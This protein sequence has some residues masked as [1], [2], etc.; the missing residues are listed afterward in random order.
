MRPSKQL[1]KPRPHFGHPHH[2]LLDP[3]EKPVQKFNQ[4][5]IRLRCDNHLRIGQKLSSASA[6]TPGSGWMIHD[7][8]HANTFTSPKAPKR[9]SKRSTATK[10]A[11]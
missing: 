1:G 9:P 11:K 10:Q 4:A 3:V 2:Q 8:N 7:D 6:G 5:G